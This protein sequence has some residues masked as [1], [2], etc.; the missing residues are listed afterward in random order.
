[1]RF[2][3]SKNQ[4]KLI[5]SLL[6][7]ITLASC[8]QVADMAGYNTQTLN[9]NA[10]KSYAQVVNQ[11]RGQGAVDSTSDTSKRIRAVFERMLPYARQANKTGVPFDWQLTVIRSKDLN[12]W[13][14]PGGKMVVYTGIVDQLRLSNDEIAAIIGH[15]MTHALLE[16]AKQA[17][18]QK[19]LTGLAMNIGGQILASQTGISSETIG[20][21]QDVLSQYG[22]G[23]PFS[24]HQENQADSGGLRLM[25][26]AGYDPR[27]ALTVWQKMNQVNQDNG[28]LVGILSTHPTNNARIAAIQQ[29]LPQILPIYEQNRHR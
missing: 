1:M 5:A 21:S 29:Q 20:I 27:A 11:A 6:A 8:V 3:F 15:E 22:I 10:A 26:E 19:V 13:A 23:L 2:L 7:A 25:A 16:H 28:A 17:A 14:M 18:G 24:R 9:A 12:A 4:Y